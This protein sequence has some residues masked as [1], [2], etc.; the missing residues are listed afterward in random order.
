MRTQFDIPTQPMSYLLERGPRCCGDCQQG[1]ADC[2][3]PVICSSK[4][5]GAE[6]DDARAEVGHDTMPATLADAKEAGQGVAEGVRSGLGKVADIC[7]A[8]WRAL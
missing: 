1:R 3:H 7:R 2:P 5:T 8:I 6:L 4:L